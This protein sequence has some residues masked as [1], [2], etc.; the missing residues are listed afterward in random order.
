[1]YLQGFTEGAGVDVILEMLANVNLQ[2]DLEI[3]KK[4]GRVIVSSWIMYTSYHKELF[5]LGCI[6]C[7]LIFFG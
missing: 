2:N 1:M 3:L 7:Q 4:Y 6:I 5:Q